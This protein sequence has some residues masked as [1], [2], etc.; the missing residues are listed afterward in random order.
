MR[1]VGC[2]LLYLD[3]WNEDYLITF[4][5][6]HIEGLLSGFP[7]PELEKCTYIT[8]SSG[9]TARID[10][11]GRGWL[12]GIKNS[13]HAKL[14]RDGDSEPLYTI[15]GQWTGSFTIRDAVSGAEIELY[16]TRTSP[17]SRLTV[18]PLEQQG[19]LE[20]RRAWSAVAEAIR[21]GNLRTVSIEKS[22]IEVAQRQL[23]AQEQSQGVKW[24]Q[25]YFSRVQSDP[26]LDEL[27]AKVGTGVGTDETGGIWKW[28]PL[29]YSG[30][31][32]LRGHQSNI[33]AVNRS[34]EK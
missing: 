26:L 3:K 2:A 15:D 22:K 19:S 12:R 8:S 7:F 27:F 33:R 1:Q 13:V 28:D 29:K 14:S 18:A 17:I 24:E 31:V 11:S 6:L 25:R 34:L 23:R 10:F 21:K 30:H 9:Y 20:S 16:D 32:Q 5:R 4:P